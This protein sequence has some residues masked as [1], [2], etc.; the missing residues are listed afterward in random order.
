MPG[1][2]AADA[3]GFVKLPNVDMVVE[4]ADMREANRSYEAN[5]QAIKQAREMISM[6]HR[7][8]EEHYDRPHLLPT[9][10]GQPARAA[11]AGADLAAARAPAPGARPKAGVGFRRDA[12]ADGR[13]CGRRGQECR[14]HVDRRHQ[15]QASVQQVVEAVMSAEQTLQ[16]AIAIRDKVVAAYLEISRM[17]I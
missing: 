15:G 2:P 8:A 9:A 5:L 16:G 17:Q 3:K 11:V 6:T 10:A 4:A 14:G 7:S 12:R 1:H 13:Q